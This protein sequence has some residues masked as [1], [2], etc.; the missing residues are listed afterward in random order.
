[1]VRIVSQRS[2]KNKY[3]KGS[4]TNHAFPILYQLKHHTLKQY[5][6]LLL[7]L[8]RLLERLLSLLDFLGDRSRSLLSGGDRLGLLRRGDLEFLLSRGDRLLDRLE[9]L[10]LPGD[11]LL[12]RDERLGDLGIFFQHKNKHGHVNFLRMREP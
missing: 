7:L 2:V 4:S 6:S 12:E 10:F 8:D 9:Y 5:L 1:M 3:G 11:L